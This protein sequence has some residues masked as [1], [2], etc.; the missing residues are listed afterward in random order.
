MREREWTNEAVNNESLNV[1]SKAFFQHQITVCFK[2]VGVR[3]SEQ[4]EAIMA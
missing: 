3:G 1:S 2:A 4:D